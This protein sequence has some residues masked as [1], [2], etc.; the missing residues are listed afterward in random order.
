M[1]SILLLASVVLS[2]NSASMAQQL[3]IQVVDDISGKGVYSEIYYVD[4][5]QKRI[6]LDETDDNGN[7]ICKDCKSADRYYAKPKNS[8]YS[9]SPYLMCKHLRQRPKMEVTKSN[10]VFNLL[11]NKIYL[12]SHQKYSE[13]AFVNAILITKTDTAKHKREYN[14]YVVSCYSNLAMAYGIND[15]NTGGTFFE[16]DNIS[17]EKF[18]PKLS[19]LVGHM[20]E[21]NNY[22]VHNLGVSELIYK[23]CPN[24]REKGFYEKNN[25]FDVIDK[26]KDPYRTD[27]RIKY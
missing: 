3:T 2:V 18:S 16:N 24:C 10:Y 25:L 27:K 7:W 20:A 12:E 4:S 11:K 19:R 14:S 21:K 23:E 1:K 22:D 9:A 26:N 17:L 8:D 15:I 13:A 5:T 6:F